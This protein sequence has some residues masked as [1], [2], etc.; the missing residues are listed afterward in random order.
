[1]RRPV[2]RSRLL[3]LASLAMLVAT[4]A[5]TMSPAALAAGPKT[6]GAKASAVTKDAGVRGGSRGSVDVSKLSG[7]AG[8]HA[9]RPQLPYLKIPT[10]V[11]HGGA[12]SGPAGPAGVGGSVVPPPPV[13]ATTTPTSAATGPEW[14]GFSFADVGTQPPD[15]WVAVGPEHVVQTVN[16][17]IQIFDRV[18][19]VEI[20]QTE[21]GIPE[22]FNLPPGFGNSDPRVIYDS[23]HGRWIG[24]EVSWTCDGDGDATADDPIGYIDF[25]VSRTADP[26]GVWDL[27]FFGFDGELPDFPAPGTSTDKLAFTANMFT[28]SP[29]PDCLFAP[30]ISRTELIVTDWVDVLAFGGSNGLVDF[31]AFALV[32]PEYN[33]GRVAVQSPATSATLHYVAERTT[34]VFPN[35]VRTPYYLKIT[36]T[37]AGT[38]AFPFETQ[39]TDAGIVAETIAPPFP[40]QPGTVTPVTTAID[41]RP[42]DA[43]W[44]N[45]LFT[46]VSTNGCTPTDDSTQRT[47]VRVTQLNTGGAITSPPT[48]AQDFLIAENGK[49][50]Y[51]GGIGQSGNGT[52]HVVWTRSSATDRPSSQTAYRLPT[53]A[54]NTLRGFHEIG[55]GT[56]GA[57]T[58]GRWGDFVGVA[59]DP[60]VPDAVWQANQFATGGENWETKVSQLQTGGAT[61]VP[62]APLRVVDSRSNVGV[63]GIFNAST[64]KTFAVAGVGTIPADAMAVTGNVTVVGQ[65]AGGYVS[66]TTTP[67]SSPGSSTLNFP[68]KDTRANNL[69]TPVASNGKLSVVYKA[70]AGKKAHI[71]FDVTGY[72]LPGAEDAA[73]NTLAPVR[74]LDSRAAY[75]IGL[76]NRFHTGV[77]RPLVI[78]GN[79]G[80]P[81]NAIAVTANL[82]VVGQTKGG[83]VSITPTSVSSPTTSNINFPVGDT[84]A[85]G[86]TAKLGAGGDIWLVYKGSA[87]SRTDLILDVTGYYL[88]GGDGLVFHALNPGRIMDTR[89]SLLS[90]LT[91]TF[92]HNASRALDTDGHWGVPAGA[93]AVTGNLTVTAQTRAGYVSI[94]PDLD[95]APT[96]ST[97]NFPLGDTRANG[98]TVPL[99]G[100]GDMSLI[101]KAAAGKKTHLI[102]DVTGYFE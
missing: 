90:G 101:Y 100:S 39:L 37:V 6:D 62:I 82:T 26:T 91:G 84:R 46:W 97:I 3:V 52:L 67:T 42:T 54:A 75:G 18:G 92:N 73:Y 16:T 24:T 12:T 35:L 51:F 32:S 38:I 25:I 78:A 69:T 23:L 96:T 76:T 63:T 65:T 93:K 22:L 71:I 87:G 9:S 55:T 30:V 49:D 80:V 61:Y 57:F 14:D 17:F 79:N 44:Q 66:V 10:N 5:F 59:Q 50:N 89:T 70:A 88:P 81:A 27:Y 53:D 72:F 77:P 19:A 4:T 102:L 11:P 21:I 15:P 60:Q 8:S 98:V 45:G 34:G 85:N 40:I 29:V 58:G 83:Y 48:P 68:V 64:P 99:N 31:D 43:I 28:L 95:P 47:C 1:M 20:P 74:V 56:G 2:R 13:Q 86:L 7:S 36:G 33:T 94:T 41:S